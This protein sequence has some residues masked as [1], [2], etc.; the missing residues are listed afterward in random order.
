MGDKKTINIG[1][2]PDFAP[3]SYVNEGKP[4]GILIDRISSIFEK[5]NIPFKFIPVE[6]TKLTESLLAGNIDILLAMAKTE[7]RMKV[8]SFS[9][10]IIITGAAWFSLAKMPP[11]LDSEAPKSVITPA[12]GPLVTQIEALFP[13]INLKTTENYDTA[14]RAVLNGEAHAAALN[15]HVGR[16]MCEEK[17]PSLFHDPIAPFNIIPLFIVTIIK[18][19]YNVIERLKPYIPEDWAFDPA[20]V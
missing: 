5:S 15:W 8:F 19:P 1:I 7:K 20:T 14:L 11:L 16:M 17:Y 6:L 10:P 3:F 18:D 9:K 12:V 4:E 2:N 13:D